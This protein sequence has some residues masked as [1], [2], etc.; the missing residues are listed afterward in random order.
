[1]LQIAQAYETVSPS[2]GQRPSLVTS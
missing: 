1:L 2:K